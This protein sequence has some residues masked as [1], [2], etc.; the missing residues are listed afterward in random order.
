MRS[1]RIVIETEQR[2]GDLDG[3]VQTL[4]SATEDRGTWRTAGRLA[5]V[6]AEL[7][8]SARSVA[9]GRSVGYRLVLSAA[10]LLERG[11]DAGLQWGELR[12]RGKRG[13][14]AREI[15]EAFDANWH[16]GPRAARRLSPTCDTA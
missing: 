7:G 3:G 16:I 8:N 6:S 15:F 2:G 1:A 11:E 12:A 14:C 13:L 9:D 4:E 5:R 10:S